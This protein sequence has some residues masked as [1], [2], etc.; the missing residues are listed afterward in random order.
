MSVPS[1]T[2]VMEKGVAYAATPAVEPSRRRLVPTALLGCLATS[3]IVV[4]ALLGG[5]SYE[6]HLAGA[7]FFGMPGGPLG[8]IGK[9]GAHPPIYAIIM[10]Y[11]GIL[12]LT[13]VWIGLLRHLIAHRGFPVKK[14][15]LIVVVWALPLLFAPPLFS[16]DVYSYAG[17]GEMVSHQ[18]DPYVYGTGI[19][20]STPFSSMPDSIW[21]NTPAPYGPTFLSIDGVLAQASGHKILPDIVLLR[22]L[23]LAGLALVVGSTPTLARRFGRD[24]AQAVLVGAGCPLVLLTLIGGAHN[25]GLMLGLLMAGLAVAVRFGTAPGIVLC[26]A[27]AGVKA[28]AALGV[29]F[30]GWMWAGPGASVRRRVVHTLGAGLIAL[31]TL[32]V[33]SFVSGTSW[34]WLRTSTAANKSFTAVTPVNAASKALSRLAAVVHVHISAHDARTVFTAIGLLCA[35]AIGIWLLLKSPDFDV[36]RNLGLTLLVVALLGPILWNW[37]VTWGVIVLAPTIT[38]S[39]RRIVIAV[40]TFEIFVGASSIKNLVS[41]LLSAGILPDLVLV[42]AIF[43]LVIVPLGQF[44]R[45]RTRRPI[46]STDTSPSLTPLQA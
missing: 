31:S 3:S 44:G 33:I 7:W 27:A 19:L 43:A 24:P 40:S 23:E 45:V 46:R 26:A 22:L 38:G 6:T 9:H 15:V 20:G 10:V 4:G 37:Y 25:E 1:N 12:I 8:S 5:S 28:P 29:L 39:L 21:T 13:R 32:E 34:G 2:S 18:I 17:Q 16:R 41:T 11:G 36:S 42:A 30:L 14:V 35:T